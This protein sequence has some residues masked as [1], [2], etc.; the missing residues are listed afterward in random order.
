MVNDEYVTTLMKT[1]KAGMV[2]MAA[3][4]GRQFSFEDSDFG[5]GHGAFNY[6]ITQALTENRQTTD[7]NQNGIIEL[8]ELYRGKK[9]PGS[10]YFVKV[11][12]KRGQAR[13]IL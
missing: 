1:G 11:E 9:G 5:N 6:A 12:E 2:V 13:I 7:T 3:S 4:K 10:D 8:S